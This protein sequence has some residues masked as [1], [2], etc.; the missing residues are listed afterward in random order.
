MKNV[1]YPSG[2]GWKCGKL[3]EYFHNIFGSW[4][5]IECEDGK[6]KKFLISEIEL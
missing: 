5:L 6:V 2:G 3:I 1:R 4:A